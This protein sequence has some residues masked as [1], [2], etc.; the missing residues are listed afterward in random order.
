MTLVVFLSHTDDLYVC[1]QSLQ[2]SGPG[3]RIVAEDVS[4]ARPAVAAAAR[5][6]VHAPGGY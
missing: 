6:P 1:L 2:G 3:G 4:A 5:T